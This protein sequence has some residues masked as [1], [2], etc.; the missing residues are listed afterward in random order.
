MST[1]RVLINNR[2]KP[3][4]FVQAW[5][6]FISFF[7]KPRDF[8]RCFFFSQQVLEYSR[9]YYMIQITKSWDKCV[10]SG[11]HKQQRNR[12]KIS[13]ENKLCAC[14]VHSVDYIT[15]HFN[16]FNASLSGCVYKKKKKN[17]NSTPSFSPSVMKSSHAL[18]QSPPLGICDSGT[19]SAVG[20]SASTLMLA[21][22]EVTG[23]RRDSKVDW[24]KFTQMHLW[25]IFLLLDTKTKLEWLW[26]SMT[27]RWAR[28][29]WCNLV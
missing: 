27:Y 4:Y 21:R 1:F 15:L 26:S 28:S 13:F 5:R 9:S 20:W 14:P 22:A 16:R 7:L 2:Q 23:Q 19:C 24:L 6:G 17:S 8:K 10:I 29:A 25:P 18:K 11:L 12:R 3:C